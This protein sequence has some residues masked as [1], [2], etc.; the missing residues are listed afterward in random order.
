MHRNEHGVFAQD[1]KRQGAT[2]ES[3]GDPI[4]VV[5]P[6]TMT[7]AQVSMAVLDVL[8]LAEM[9]IDGH[10]V[11]SLPDGGVCFFVDAD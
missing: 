4:V 6:P 9:N 7:S 3:L 1:L 5:F 8:W 10:G 2:I 11:E